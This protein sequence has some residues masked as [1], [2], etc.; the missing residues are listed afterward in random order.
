[1]EKSVEARFLHRGVLPLDLKDLFEIYR[2]LAAAIPPVTNPD[3]ES[4]RRFKIV[5]ASRWDMRINSL[6]ENA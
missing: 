6:W 1:M 5:T 3:P 4:G 2:N